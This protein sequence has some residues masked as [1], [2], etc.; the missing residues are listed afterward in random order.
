[1]DFR[2]KTLDIIRPSGIIPQETITVPSVPKERGKLD[3]MLHN[4]NVYNKID[5]HWK[6]TW[7]G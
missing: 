1:M 6:G 4:N 5:F 3:F 7:V 2:K